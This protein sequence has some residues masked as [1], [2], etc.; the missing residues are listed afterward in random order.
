[1]SR[2]VLD[3]FTLAYERAGAGGPIVFI[4]GALNRHQSGG[5]SEHEMHAPG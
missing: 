1:M 4:H 5:W 3:G 2:A